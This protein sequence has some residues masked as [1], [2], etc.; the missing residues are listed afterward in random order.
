MPSMMAIVSKAVFEKDARGK[1][2]GDVWATDR[3]IS[4]NKALGALAGGDLY[5]VTVRPPDEALWLVAVL[6]APQFDG[7]QWHAN[8]N[9]V[10]ICDISHLKRE[11][12]FA[13]G[14]GLPDKAGT[15]GMSL[16]TPRVLVPDD[17]ELLGSTA[18][19]AKPAAKA[20]ASTKSKP[21]K[22]TKSRG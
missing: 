19:A 5:L 3:Y 8:P 6:S 14:Q 2:I 7:S 10:P 1:R 21:P 4:Q 15:L 22:Q 12:A 16:Q 11:L 18:P 20:P 13:N 9:T 17:L